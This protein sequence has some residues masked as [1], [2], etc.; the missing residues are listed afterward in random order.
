MAVSR[1]RRTSSRNLYLSPD[2]KRTL[3]WRFNEYPGSKAALGH[4]DAGNSKP[5]A[6]HPKSLNSW[7]KGWKSSGLGLRGFGFGLRVRGRC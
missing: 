6:A 1:M 2:V 7:M 5:K 4:K 3:L